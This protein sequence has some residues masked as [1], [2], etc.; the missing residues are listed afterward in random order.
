MCSLLLA[1]VPWCHSQQHLSHA[2]QTPSLCLETL[3]SQIVRLTACAR[4]LLF[5]GFNVIDSS[6]AMPC[7]CNLKPAFNQVLTFYLIRR[8]HWKYFQ[9][10]E[11]LGLVLILSLYQQNELQSI[12]AKLI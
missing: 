7:D 6:D 3:Q 2:L 8:V 4:I 11:R 10:V 5:G 1:I 12:F 9:W